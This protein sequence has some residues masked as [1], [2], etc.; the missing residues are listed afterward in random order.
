MRQRRKGVV[1]VVYGEPARREARA[2]IE[3]LRRR[4]NWPIAVISDQPAIQ[5]TRHI[6]FAERDVGA[7]WAKLHLDVLSPFDQTLYLDADT[8]PY[9]NL[10]AGFDI[11]ADGWD[12]AMTASSQQGGSFLWHCGEDDREATLAAWGWRPLALQAGAM[13]LDRNERTQ[14]L[15]GAWR[16]EWQRFEGQDQGALL[17]ALRRAPARVWL[18][19]RPWN[20]GAVVGHRFGVARRE[21]AGF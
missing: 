12:V 9:Q 19:G 11:L 21:R 18:L 8:R 10:S 1:Y 4:H 14:R 7:R 20:G 5:G 3:M 15:F 16:E 17:R 2:S 6:Q 13:F